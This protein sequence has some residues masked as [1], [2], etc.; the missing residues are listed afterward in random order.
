MSSHV[1]TAFSKRFSKLKQSMIDEFEHIDSL[2]S[3]SPES[4]L[5]PES[6]ASAP[7]KDV[8][9]FDPASNVR[10]PLSEGAYRPEPAVLVLREMCVNHYGGSCDR[11]VRACPMGCI[12]IGQGGIPRVDREGCTLCGICLGVCDAFTSNDVTMADL[13]VRIRRASQRGE[14]VVVTCPL[15]IDE[16]FRPAGN[17]VEVPCLAALSPEFWT[18]LLAQGIDLS[19]AADLSRCVDCVRGGDVAEIL[20]THAI[21]TAQLWVG[22]SISFMDEVP[23]DRGLVGEFASEGHF[24]RRGAFAHIAGG[25]ADVTTGEYRRRN[26]AVLQDFYERR[27]R[28]RANA[29]LIGSSLPE[30]NRFVAGGVSKRSMQPKRRLLQEAIEERPEI[31][32]RVTIQVSATDV[33]KC[34][35]H[36]DCTRCCPTGARLP[37]AQTGLLDYDMRYCIGCALCVAACSEAAVSMREQPASV[38]VA[39]NPDGG[40]GDALH[41]L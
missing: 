25:V 26:S 19:I 30:G 16:G 36:L 14:G 11:C 3:G 4:S 38:L 9:H 5:L 22:E 18:A 7:R 1:S 20:Y 29:R 32:E 33:E 8:L 37:N 6:E 21:E 35:Q 39:V 31:G 24:D 13:A 27:D 34:A 17:V 40:S 2:D 41:V 12:E 10:K 23:E 28:M 15:N